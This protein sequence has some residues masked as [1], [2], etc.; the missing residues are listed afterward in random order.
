MSSRTPLNPLGLSGGGGTAGAT[1]GVDARSDP[2]AAA[3]GLL[4]KY[5]TE[6]PATAMRPG[7]AMGARPGTAARTRPGSARG[8]RPPVSPRAEVMTLDTSSV[9]EDSHDLDESAEIS[10]G[11]GFDIDRFDANASRSVEADAAAMD[12]SD[13]A[14]FYDNDDDGGGAE[15]T[16]FSDGA[17]GIV[18][19][20]DSL[21]DSVSIDFDASARSPATPATR[22]KSAPRRD[23]DLSMSVDDDALGDASISVDA[24]DFATA[25]ATAPRA[26]GRRRTGRHPRRDA[27]EERRRR[28]RVNPSRPRRGRAR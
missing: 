6:R 21:G 19:D 16:T 4:G 1:S 7:T 17:E 20:D 5:S 9:A 2:L 11:D 14:A 12:D 10:Y 15:V 18:L 24:D 22:P 8:G 27:R 13:D 26:R 23:V 3:E 28:R 25:A